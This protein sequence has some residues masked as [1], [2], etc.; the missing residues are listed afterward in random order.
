MTNTK[1]TDYTTWGLAAARPATPANDSAAASFY[2]ATDTGALSVYANGAWH[3]VTAVSDDPAIVQQKSV[4]NSN[5]VTLSSGPV[6][7]NLLLAITDDPGVSETANTGWTK[8]SF[9]SAA[10]DGVGFYWKVAGAAESTT[11]QPI[12][13]TLSTGSTTIFEISNATPSSLFANNVDLSGTAINA[14][15]NVARNTNQLVIGVVTNRTTNAPT[16][17]TGA[18]ILSGSASGGSRHAAPF[19]IT[20][21]VQGSNTVTANFAGSEGCTIPMIEIG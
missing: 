4:V 8:I 11:Q 18:T 17:I 5:S 3:S 20:T 1:I 9:V 19:K 6:Q 15:V 10:Q 2:Y 7:H 21:P 16:S 14:S 13:G 12:T